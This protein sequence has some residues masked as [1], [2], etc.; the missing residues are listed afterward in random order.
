MFKSDV[1][2]AVEQSVT[3]L[4]PAVSFEM[5]HVSVVPN[6]AWSDRARFLAFLTWSRIHLIFVA[7]KY[8]SMIRLVLLRMVRS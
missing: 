3:R 2:E 8:G 1:R 7:E 5:T 4:L 6:T